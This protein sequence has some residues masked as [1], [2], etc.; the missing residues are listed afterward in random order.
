MRVRDVMVRNV[1]F[2]SPE[3]NLAAVTEKLWKEGCGTLPVVENGRVL[4][5][6]TDRDICIA[7]GTRNRKAAD[8]LVKDVTLPKLFFCSP[9]DDIHAALKTMSAQKVRR[10]PVIDNKGALQGILC[11]DDI[12]LFA[13]EK[14]A[15]L[16]Y[17]DVVQTM[18]SICEHGEMLKTLAV[19]R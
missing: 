18:K 12:V 1:K 13:E 16:T 15:D 2:C 4:G 6:V 3:A 9:D 11:L 7:L 10:L 14:A 5:I 17:F 8:V 19:A